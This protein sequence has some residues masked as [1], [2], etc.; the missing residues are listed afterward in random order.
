MKEWFKL[1]RI[2]KAKAKKGVKQGQGV[3]K[4]CETYGVSGI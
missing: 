4:T 3:S 2:L 1:A